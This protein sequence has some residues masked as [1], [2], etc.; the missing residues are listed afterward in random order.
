MLLVPTV[1]VA[2][3]EAVE[4]LLSNELIPRPRRTGGRALL[5]LANVPCRRPQVLSAM[6]EAWS[7]VLS[8]ALLVHYCPKSLKYQY[9]Y[10]QWSVLRSSMA[11]PSPVGA[12]TAAH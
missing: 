4:D 7:L 12:E 9:L 10:T 5:H 6:H 1:S 8:P 2:A 3:T 11:R